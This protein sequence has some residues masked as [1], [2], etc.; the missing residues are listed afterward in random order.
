MLLILH[1]SQP[2]AYL[3]ATINWGAIVGWSAVQ[4]YCDWSVVL[5]LYGAGVAWTIVY[6]TI[7]ACQVGRI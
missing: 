1:A 6:D 4:G 5:P 2:Q 7:Y 3:G